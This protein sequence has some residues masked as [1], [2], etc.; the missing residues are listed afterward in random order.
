[1]SRRT[2]TAAACCSFLAGI[3]VTAVAAWVQLQYEN[4]RETHS[5][6]KLD[7]QIE[8]LESDVLASR[9]EASFG[10]YHVEALLRRESVSK[11]DHETDHKAAQ[12]WLRR[13][14]EVD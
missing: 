2:L 3:G 1:M 11:S 10:K 8:Q 9:D 6:W 4:R 7:K 12:D 13:M 14:K 5:V